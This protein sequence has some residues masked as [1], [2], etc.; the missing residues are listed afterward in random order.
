MAAATVSRLTTLADSRA[1]KA[2]DATIAAQAS[3]V[4]I[5]S[6]G[7]ADRR[8]GDKSISAAPMMKSG[9]PIDAAE[10]TPT[11]HNPTA[12]PQ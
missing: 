4:A 9:R 6:K 11:A 8:S 3:P 2:S 12:A 1:A 10:T 5:G 7:R